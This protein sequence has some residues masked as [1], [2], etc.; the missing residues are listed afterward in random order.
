MSIQSSEMIWRH[1]VERSDAGSNGGR[2]TATQIPTSVKNNIWPDVPQSER[3]A[4]STKYRKVFIHISNDD[5]LTLVRPR[6]F[7]ETFTPGDDSITI[8]SGTMTDN[9]STLSG[10]EPQYGCGDLNSDVSSGASTVSV[11]TE[12]ASLDYFRAGDLIRISDKADVNAIG[13]EE[14]LTISSVGSYVGDVVTLTIST[15]LV[16]GYV[17]SGVTRVGSV[18]EVSDIIATYSSFSVVTAD[19]GTYDDATYPVVLDHIS[20][21]EQDWTITFTSVTDFT[22]TSDDPT[23]GISTVGN[24]SSTLQPNNPDYN[25]PYFILNQLGYGGSFAIGDTISFTTTPSAAPIWYKRVIPANANSL[26][27][28][29]VIIGIDGESA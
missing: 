11:L 25:K 1:P 5:D 27:G 23:L 4:G 15:P 28:D 13:N 12:G 9:Q 17:A 2:M 10:S 29:K 6:I 7:V 22:L 21:I 18:I 24:V 19:T 20:S 26:T 16:N 14:Y 3:I 8:F